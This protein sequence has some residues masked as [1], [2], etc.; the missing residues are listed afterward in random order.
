LNDNGEKGM[1]IGDEAGGPVV[2][3]KCRSSESCLLKTGRCLSVEFFFLESFQ[4][5]LVSSFDYLCDSLTMSSSERG[6]P[7]V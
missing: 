6:W 1:K 4:V 7:S 2:D 3:K 5:G